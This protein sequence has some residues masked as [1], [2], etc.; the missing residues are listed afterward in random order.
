[1]DFTITKSTGQKEKFEARKLTESLIRSGA[2]PD[3][4]SEIARAVAREMPPSAHTRAIYR[5]ARRLLKKYSA[6]SGMKYSLKK[7]ISSLGPSG[8]PFEKYMA[9]VLRS[10][11]Y[12]AEVNKI[13][14]GYCVSHEVDVVATREN[15]YA[16]VECKYH[17]NGG[18]PTDVKVA[19]Y[20]HSRFEDIRKVFARIPGEENADY[21]GWLVT[22]TRCTTDAIRYAECAGLKIVSWRYPAKESLEK[23]IEEKRLYPVTV[24]PAARKKTL[25]SLFNN[26]IILAQEIADMGE[27][28]F[29]RRSGLDEAT[30]RAIKRQADAL[31]PCG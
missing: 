25:D 27:R 10:H 16:V 21:Q 18:T 5:M 15:E 24:L 2:P 13:I 17:I 11:G 6:V 19:L 26:D 4:A 20:V 3:V 7:A 30:A 12:K 1:M 28:D 14:Q 9:R 8:Y 22:N 23:M 29:L 31:C